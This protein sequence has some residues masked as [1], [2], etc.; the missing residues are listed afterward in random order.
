MGWCRRVGAQIWDYL[1]FEQSRDYLQRNQLCLPDSS[2]GSVSS[3]S[4]CSLLCPAMPG[5]EKAAQPGH[6]QERVCR[7]I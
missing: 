6:G 4:S 2:L 7:T 5:M 1:S 3:Q